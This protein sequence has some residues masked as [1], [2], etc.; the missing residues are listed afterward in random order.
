MDPVELGK[1]LRTFR[2]SQGSSQQDVASHLAVPRTAIT[3]IEKGQRQV[4]TVELTK[5]AE[6]YRRT[7]AEFLQANSGNDEDYLVVLHRMAPE[8]QGDPNVKVDVETS[9]ELCRIGVSLEKVLHLE[10]RQGPP[11]YALP[12]RPRSAAEA[13][14]QGFEVAAEERRRLGLGSAPIRNI[15]ARINEQG[16]W[17]VTRKL[18]TDMAGFF[19]H[20]PEIGL[21]VVVNARHPPARQTFSFAH[22]YGHA[23]MDRHETQAHVQVTKTGNSDELVEKRANA[24]AAAFLLPRSGVEHFLASIGKGSGGRQQQFF[25][26]V[27]SN[28]KFDVDVRERPETQ[29]ITPQDL[30]FLATNFGVSYEAAA[31]RLNTL[32]FLTRAETQD[33]LAKAAVAARYAKLLEPRR[34]QP[35]SQAYDEQDDAPDP[36]LNSQ[37]LH[38]AVEAFRRE[39]ISRGRLLEIGRKLQIDGQELLELVQPA[40]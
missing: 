3:L 4:T 34:K 40:D 33:L 22:E 32:R 10:A 21:V 5:L 20:H 39:E 19:M 18:S 16:V 30:G 25:Y 14:N 11:N 2:E 17:A 13:I 27:A 24:F 12:K 37:I 36:E 9:L 26:D 8:L 38:L 7:V 23:L 15:A 28:G 31:Y 1:R 6:L 29:T 35:Q